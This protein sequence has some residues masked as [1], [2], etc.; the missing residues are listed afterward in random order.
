LITLLKSFQIRLSVME[1]GG[2]KRKLVDSLFMTPLQKK[3]KLQELISADNKINIEGVAQSKAMK[4]SFENVT[5]TMTMKNNFELILNMAPVISGKPY[6]GEKSNSARDETSAHGQVRYATEEV[7]AQERIDQIKE[8][9]GSEEAEASNGGSSSDVSESDDVSSSFEEADP[10]LSSSPY[11]D[12]NSD[13]EELVEQ[14]KFWNV[15]Q[16]EILQSAVPSFQFLPRTTTDKVA[17]E[18]MALEG[19]P[20][21]VKY[22]ARIWLERRDREGEDRLEVRRRKLKTVDHAQ[23][24]EPRVSKKVRFMV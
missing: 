7:K 8:N 13:T 11:E 12:D 2:K 14:E 18:L 1:S 3:K 20:Y 24:T 6:H 15:E 22:F 17:T 16:M 10:L 5:E 9:V 23:G 21:R 4:S 19:C